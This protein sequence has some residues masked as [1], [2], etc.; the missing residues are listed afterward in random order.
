MEAIRE[1][2]IM[3]RT[4]AAILAKR[5]QR[6]VTEDTAFASV[7][8]STTAAMI[9]RLGVQPYLAF[10]AV[11]ATHRVCM[12]DERTSGFTVRPVFRR[13]TRVGDR[14]FRRSIRSLEE[15]GLLEVASVPGRKQRIRL[16]D[17]GLAAASLA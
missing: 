1:T 9:D 12:S 2:E 11:I 7:P 17:E 14:Q 8:I 16:T 5:R 3:T 4:K 15:A 10:L 6:R 13:A